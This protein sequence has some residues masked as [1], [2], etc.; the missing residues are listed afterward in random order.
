MAL[1]FARF[2]S[3]VLHPGVLQVVLLLLAVRPAPGHFVLTCMLLL[4]FL[5]FGIYYA[6]VKRLGL[7]HTYDLPRGQRWL[8]L[9]VNLA[10]LGALLWVYGGAFEG[11]LYVAVGYLLWV[12]LLAGG[13]TLAGYK[14][15]L[16]LTALSALGLY[17]MLVYEP[18]LLWALPALLLAQLAL[19]WARHALQ[20]HSLN[21]LLWGVVLGTLAPFGY[22]LV[23][24]GLGLG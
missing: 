4:A 16:H 9:V 14:I 23:L 11:R 21:Q 13:I 3:V 19:G 8:L 2:L 15:S 6:Q 7:A 18:N 17:L 24:Q 20:A 1:R 10:S 22:Q 12:V 5:P